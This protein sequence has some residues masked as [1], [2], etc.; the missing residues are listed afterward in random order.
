MSNSLEE[1]VLEIVLLKIKEKSPTDNAFSDH[2]KDS[3]SMYK[4]FP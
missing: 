2:T 1:Y 3:V 4:V